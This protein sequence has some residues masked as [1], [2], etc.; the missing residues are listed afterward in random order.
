MKKLHYFLLLASLLLIVPFRTVV[1][2][3][4]GEPFHFVT[5]GDQGCGCPA[6]KKLSERMLDWHEKY[7]FSVVITTG[8]NIY[9]KG[10]GVRG[11]SRLLFQERFD[12]YY[13]P[14]LDRGVKF[15]ATLGNHDNETNNGKDE[16]RDKQRFNILGDD[17]YYSFSPS[18]EV[19]GKPLVTF[20]ALNSTRL[21][22]FGEDPSQISWL[23]KTLAESEALWKIAY[24]HHPLHAP[25]GAHKAEKELKEGIENILR[26]AGV[27]LTLTGHNHYYARMKPEDG[28]LHIISGGGGRDLKKPVKTALTDNAVEAYHFLYLEVLPDKIYFWSI[29]ESGGPLDEGT[30]T[31]K[32]EN[33]EF[34][35]LNSARKLE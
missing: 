1:F 23:S 19:D 28:I 11:G 12:S 27:Q 33:Q 9:G 30:I 26:A 32:M 31:R 13:K 5:I 17:G 7:P 34:R 6:Q 2:G 18:V 3:L 21:L 8:D 14:L 24:F 16:I 10:F 20:F 25:E 22:E 29:P 15:Y 4:A 35:V